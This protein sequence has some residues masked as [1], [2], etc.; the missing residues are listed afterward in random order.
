MLHVGLSL[1]KHCYST[2]E[3]Q[4]PNCCIWSFFYSFFAS[5]LFFSFTVWIR[6]QGC[7]MLQC[8]NQQ[9]LI[10]LAP[11][12][13]SFA[14]WIANSWS[15]A[16]NLFQEQ[17]LALPRW[18]LP[19]IS[20]SLSGLSQVGCWYLS[21]VKGSVRKLQVMIHSLHAQ[22]LQS[23][24]TLYLQSLPGSSV[25]GISQARALES[26]RR[27]SRPKDWTLISCIGRWILYN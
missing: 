4:P 18:A 17:G 5:S 9:S 3:I 26:F 1:E 7:L 15:K 20:N 16:V 12:E 2:P 27:S 25:P 10:G 21:L 6:G 24:L 8:N 23:C 11:W 14:R 13:K 22:W 19:N